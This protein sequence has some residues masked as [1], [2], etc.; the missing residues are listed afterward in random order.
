M[1]VIILAVAAILV[2]GSIA[3]FSSVAYQAYKDVTWEKRLHKA[4]DKFF[5]EAQAEAAAAGRDT[6]FAP[7]PDKAALPTASVM[8]AN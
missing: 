7:V 4:W 2:V 5:R 3:V 6:L 8:K 1:E